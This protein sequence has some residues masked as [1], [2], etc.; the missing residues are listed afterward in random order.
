MIG[1]PPMRDDRPVPDHGL[2]WLQ[3]MA[4]AQ[5][6]GP[7]WRRRIGVA[8]GLALLC[9]FILAAW[10]LRAQMGFGPVAQGDYGALSIDR[11]VTQIENGPAA[12]P[13]ATPIVAPVT[14]M[15]VPSDVARRVNAAIPFSTAPNLPAR[16]FIFAGSLGERERATTCLALG[17]FYEAGDDPAGQAAVI[18]VILNRVRHP[19][20]P[21]NICAVVTQGWERATGC[22]FTFTC[23][24]AMSRRS[25]TPATMARA[26]AAAIGALYGA[27]FAPVGQATH[28]HTEWVLPRWSAQMD[29]ITRFHG[30][31]FFR[32]RGAWGLPSAFRGI[33]AGPEMVIPRF[34]SY[35]PATIDMLDGLEAGSQA[36][37]PAAQAGNGNGQAGVATPTVQVAGIGAV[38]ATGSVVRADEA[39]H[40]YLVHFPGA[41]YPGSYAVTA[42]KICAGRSPCTV[43]GFRGDDALPATVGAGPP[44]GMIFSFRKDGSSQTSLWNCQLIDRDNPAQCMA[45]TLRTRPPGT[46]AKAESGG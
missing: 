4:I 18:Q 10:I 20:F 30:H 42:W 39:R 26:R 12:S 36:A 41:D 17:A 43:Y 2:T 3:H 14:Y 11:L 19:A 38:A 46:P 28:Y 27:V 25:P 34:A 5:P 44:P 29:K 32:W 9:L 23:D 21:K 33:Y 35:L 45:G 15:A 1:A 37:Q 8:M 40:I 22:Q 13:A 6:L 24:G 31:L 16:P 7:V